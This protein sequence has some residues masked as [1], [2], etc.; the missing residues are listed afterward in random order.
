MRSDS[1]VQ[2]GNQQLSAGD[3]SSQLSS[4]RYSGSSDF[5]E[6][7]TDRKQ[8]RRDGARELPQQSKSTG[9]QGSSDDGDTMGEMLIADGF[10]D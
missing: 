5:E 6:S 2:N 4:L 3:A 7:T 8:A 1:P 10:G 9:S